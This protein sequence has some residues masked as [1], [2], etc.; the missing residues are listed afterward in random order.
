MK[1]DP[2]LQQ[3]RETAWRRPLTAAESAELQ[4]RL[5]GDPGAAA[6]WQLEARLATAL[7]RLPDADVSSNF[8][9]RVVAEVERELDARERSRPEWPALRRWLP[10][11]AFAC[12]VIVVSLGGIRH[13]E[14]VARQR[15]AESVAVLSPAGALPS[16]E[17]LADFDTIRRLGDAPAAD[18]EL[19]SLMQK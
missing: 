4:R 14:T 1:D 15:M 8:T 13:F 16:A 5:A 19:I 10:R 2:V 6:D 3:L 9:S 11:L 7:K 17:V 18:V 12:G